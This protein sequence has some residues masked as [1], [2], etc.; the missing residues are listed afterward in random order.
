MAQAPSAS[1]SRVTAR[2]VLS[3]PRAYPHAGAVLTA[4]PLPMTLGSCRASPWSDA[5]VIDPSADMGPAMAGRHLGW[6]QGWQ[7]MASNGKLAPPFL[8]NLATSALLIENRA[9]ASC[10]VQQSRVTAN[11]RFPAARSAKPKLLT[12]EGCRAGSALQNHRSQAQPVGQEFYELRLDDSD[13]SGRPGLVV[14][15]AH[16]AWNETDR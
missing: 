9:H 14:S 15:E 8:G 3:R 4:E 7:A 6:A 2:T 13:N 1:A 10:C 16:A 5:S 11:D 12:D